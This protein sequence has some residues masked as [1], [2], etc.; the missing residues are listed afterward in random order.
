MRKTVLT[1]GLISGSI[2]SL[3]MII[4]MPFHEQIGFDRATVIGFTTMI[5]AFLLI[6]F[7]AR[8]YRDNVA[9]GTVRFGRAFTVGALIAVIAAVMYTATWEVV[10]FGFKP[11]FIEKY[12]AHQVESARA[13]GRT[14]QELDKMIAEGA[15]FAERYRNPVINIGYTLGEILPL[16]LVIALISAAMVSRKRAHEEST[17][18][19]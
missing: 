12:N 1:F 16:G 19:A 15:V 4:T 17:A 7:G 13:R 10:F 11:D 14:P 18:R 8:S 3:M 5:A 6:Y 2:V 9:G